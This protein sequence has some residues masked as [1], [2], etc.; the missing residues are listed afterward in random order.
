VRK[1]KDHVNH[2]PLTVAEKNFKTSLSTIKKTCSKPP[3]YTGKVN[4]Q[5]VFNKVIEEFMGKEGMELTTETAKQMPKYKNYKNQLYKMIPKPFK[6]IPKSTDD[7][8]LNDDLYRNTADGRRFLLFDTNDQDRIICHASD[9]QLEC[10]SMSKTWHVDGTFKHS[11]QHYYQFYI[12]SAWI[13]DEMYPCAFISLKNKNE[14]CY[15]KMLKQLVKHTCHPL[16]P[17]VSFFKSFLIIFL[18]FLYII[19]QSYFCFPDCSW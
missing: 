15:E 7:I 5:R 17:R 3:S 9:H 10:L 11:A 18:I 14:S 12:I 2:P 1:P 16:A 13:L 8:Q 19:I 6:E 4:P